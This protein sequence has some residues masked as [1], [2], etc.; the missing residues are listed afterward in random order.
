MFRLFICNHEIT[1]PKLMVS[2]KLR[3]DFVRQINWLRVT[4]TIKSEFQRLGGR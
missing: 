1:L 3:R 2:A 4:E